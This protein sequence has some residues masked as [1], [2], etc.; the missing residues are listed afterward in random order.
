VWQCSSLND[1]VNDN[2]VYRLAKQVIGLKDVCDLS[3]RQLSIIKAVWFGSLALIVAVL[4]P[5]LAFASFVVRE[6][7]PRVIIKEVPVEKIV[8]VETIKEVPVE[9]IIEVEVIKEITIDRQVPVEVI[10][11]VPVDK[12]VFKEVPVEVI[13]KEVV[14]IPVYTDDK[15]LLGKVFSE[16]DKK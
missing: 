9:K 15:T 8:E 11:E 10:K 6:N 5:I 4:G 7:K 2:P 16:K 1:Q 3:E 13:R 14:H 12:V